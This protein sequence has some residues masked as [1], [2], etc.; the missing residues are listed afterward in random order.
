M[1]DPE[2]LRA[3]TGIAFS[4]ELTEFF[5]SARNSYCL[6]KDTL[7]REYILADNFN[8][9]TWALDRKR[10]R[11][12]HKFALHVGSVSAPRRSSTALFWK[13]IDQRLGFVCLRTLRKNYRRQFCEW[14]AEI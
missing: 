6:T 3:S 14:R 8:T 10:G 1:W 11:F 7:L 4:S 12:R 9:R 5:P 2:H 13:S